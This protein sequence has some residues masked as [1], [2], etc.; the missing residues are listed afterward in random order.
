MI[1]MGKDLKQ[2]RIKEFLFTIKSRL[3]YYH[4]FS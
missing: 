1:V 3:L 2:G 4:T